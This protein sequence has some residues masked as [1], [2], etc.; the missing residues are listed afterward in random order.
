MGYYPVYLDLRGRRCVV[1][2]GGET[3][4]AKVRGLLEAEAAV[5][6]IAPELT[7]E[8]DDLAEQGCIEVSRRPYREGDL[9][10]AWLAIDATWDAAVNARTHAEAGRERVAL[11]VVDRPR[12]CHFIAPAVVRRGRLQLAVSTAGESPFLAAALR[13]RLERDYGPEWGEFTALI[14]R[15][16]RRLRRRGVPWAEQSRVYRRLLGSNVLRLLAEGRRR[17]A[18]WA[19][20]VIAAGGGCGRVALVG[21]GPGDPR[22]LTLAARDLLATADLVF[23][24]DLV[25][26]QTLALCRPG[27]ELVD[28]GKRAGRHRAVQEDIN[29]ALVSAARRGEQAVRLKGGDP[30]VFGRGGEEVEAL[31]AA[32]VEV[33]VV[34]GVSSVVAAPGLAGIPLTHRGLA[35]SFGVVSGHAANVD[36][37]GGR[38]ERVAACVDTLVVLMPLGRLEE[39]AARLQRVLG[40]DRP[41]AMVACASRPDQQ[42]VRARLRNLAEAVRAAGMVTPATLVVGEVTNLAWGCAAPLAAGATR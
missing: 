5:T 10:G 22:L 28:V 23:H 1:V 24:D 20:E 21:A 14:G 39:L 26:P 40:P 36:D 34:P 29:Q 35:A 11:N 31:A 19:A 25:S 12:R 3:A 16:R 41:A 8:L 9:R 30:F 2:G 13:A 18:E 37:D 38:L 7:P 4:T 27:A 17:E 33:V 6:V 32:G 42:V 15:I